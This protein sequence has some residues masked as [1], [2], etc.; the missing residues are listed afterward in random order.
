MSQTCLLP[1]VTAV[2]MVWA[3]AGAL[4]QEEHSQLTATLT[5][6]ALKNIRDRAE[7]DEK[8]RKY[9]TS[10]IATMDAALRN[11]DVIYKGRQLN[12]AENEKLRSA[13]LESVRETLDF[14]SKAR[15]F[16]KSLPAMAIG[17]AGSITLADYLSQQKL[18]D[19]KLWGLGLLFAA[20]GYL[21]NLT[22]TK[23]MQRRKQVLYV[24]QDYE[25]SLYYDHYVTRVAMTLTSLYLD[26]DRIHRNIFGR[27]Y[28]VD[29][30]ADVI[31]NEMLKG[32]RPTFCP[33]IH[34]HMNEKIITPELWSKCETGKT[35][36]TT[37]CPNWEGKK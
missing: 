18:S 7:S 32:V 34:K 35:D 19:L 21:V 9:V 14:G 10:C 27:S 22:V 33:Y 11:L 29:A 17:G 24:T 25:R 37:V 20:V 26:L 15:D 3:R 28:P 13:Y 8:E 16:F 5:E 4:S 1:P 12:F 36:Y 2:R 31:V 30:E 23:S 6:A